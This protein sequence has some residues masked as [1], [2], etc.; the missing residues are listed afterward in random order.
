MEL[1][2]SSDVVSSSAQ[3]VKIAVETKQPLRENTD[4]WP[5]FTAYSDGICYE[6]YP[7]ESINDSLV[8][9]YIDGQWFKVTIPGY[10]LNEIT[11][12]ISQNDSDEARSFE[13]RE[14]NS[15]LCGC[16]ITQEAH[17]IGK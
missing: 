14:D 1:S 4:P 8:E 2:P 13:L 10:P 11:V 5:I 9:H 7:E 6:E 16:T 3:T 15:F 17:P 12:K